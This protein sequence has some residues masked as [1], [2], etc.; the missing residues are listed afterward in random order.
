MPLAILGA[1]HFEHGE[2]HTDLVNLAT[3]TPPVT[4]E[5][6][7]VSPD[8]GVYCKRYVFS[9]NDDV[10]YESGLVFTRGSISQSML[11][12][13]TLKISD[14]TQ[15]DNV[16]VGIFGDSASGVFP[17]A[18]HFDASGGGSVIRLSSAS[19]TSGSGATLAT[20]PAGS[21]VSG[22]KNVVTFRMIQHDTTG[23]VQVRV[24][25]ATVA[26]A[27]GVDTNQGTTV[28]VGWGWGLWISSNATGVGSPEARVSNL[29]FAQD[30][31]LADLKPQK[32]KAYVPDGVT[33]A[34]DRK[35]VV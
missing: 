21:F 24:N 19:F 6:S 2:T 14:L 8:D 20:I 18:A 12:Q 32:Y 17:V 4:D 29:T 3:S 10:R 13:A 23:E 9:N 30:G 28:Q 26:A 11:V 31:A 27:T 7:T 1:R 22:I 33:A 16:R 15:F 25:G 34:K 5:I 35:S